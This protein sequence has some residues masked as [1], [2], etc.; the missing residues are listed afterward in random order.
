MEEII[1]RLSVGVFGFIATE[2][3]QTIDLF[4]GILSQAVIIALT[5]I[6]IYKMTKDLNK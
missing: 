6:S 3:L 5:A 2:S 1:Q 4:M